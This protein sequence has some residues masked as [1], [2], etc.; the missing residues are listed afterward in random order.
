MFEILKKKVNHGAGVRTW[1]VLIWALLA[2]MLPQ[3]ASAANQVQWQLDKQVYARNEQIRASFQNLP[4]PGTRHW[5]GIWAYP[6]AGTR[7]GAWDRASNGGQGS[8][9]WTYLPATA[10]GEVALAGV[11]PGR[12]AAFLLADDGYGWLSTPIVFWVTEDG[13]AQRESGVLTSDGRAY[14]EGDAVSLSYSGIAPAPKNWIGVWR[15]VDG[16]GA[17]ADGPWNFA[18]SNASSPWQYVTKASGDWAVSSLPAGIYAAFL[19]ANDGYQWLAPPAIFEVKAKP[20]DPGS[21]I[22][23]PA[24]D[25]KSTELKVLQFNIWMR[26]TGVGTGGP[27]MIAD[28]IR[29]S[30]AD[31]ITLS[32]SDA[33]YAQRLVNDLARRGY[34]FHVYGPNKD[35]SVVSRYPILETGEFNRFSKAV[36]DV[37]GTPVAVYSGHLAYQW[38][39]CYLPRGYGGGT[40]AG[41]PTSEYGWNKIPGGPITD[42]PL[43]MDLNEKSGRPESIRQFVA[44]AKQEIE[45]GRLVVMAGDFNEPSH[46]D[47]SAATKDLYDHHGTI[48]P[49]QSTTL[50]EQAGYL[51]AYRAK[52]PDPVTHPGFTWPS[53]NPAVATSQLTWAP[54]ADERDRIDYVFYRPDDRLSLQA[55]TVVGPRK[56][57]LR[58]QRVAETGDDPILEPLGGWPT[59]HKSV[60]ATFVIQPMALTLPQLAGGTQNRAYSGSLA[61]L[62]GAAPYRYSIVSGSLP[63]GVLLAEDGVLSGTPTVSGR[64]PFTVQV[65]DANDSTAEREYVIEVADQVAGADLRPVPTMSDAAMWLLGLMLIVL[66]ARRA[67]VLNLGKT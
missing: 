17:T 51:D 56:S 24:F 27:D 48:V 31:V 39:V 16:P 55:A 64:F 20:I 9:K 40:P 7:A 14:E 60:M 15:Y 23:P 26:G 18:Q 62:G 57:I 1:L 6:D 35:V 11:A 42:V 59:D 47:W 32:E 19:L 63:P 28:V 38:Y 46:L 66:G 10:A 22:G 37:N 53:D 25:G 65:R 41:N 2:C 45:K 67:K 43:I 13:S 36:I 52:Y 3:H 34:R 49:W 44:D 4:T 50:L 33:A 54:E 58:N 12:Y 29:D 30:G 61:V 21:L 8:L 5:V